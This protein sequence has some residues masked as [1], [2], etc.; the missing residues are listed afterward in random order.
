[1]PDSGNSVSINEENCER[2]RQIAIQVASTLTNSNVDIKQA[3]YLPQSND[4][5]PLIGK[6]HGLKNVYVAAVSYLF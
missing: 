4:G 1:M 5:Y 2:L 3:C 6:L